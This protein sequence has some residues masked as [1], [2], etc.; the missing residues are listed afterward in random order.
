MKRKKRYC[1][2]CRWRI[3]ETECRVWARKDGHDSP[4]Q[5]IQLHHFASE[6]QN[7]NNDCAWFQFS[8]WSLIP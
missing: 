7:R 8:F 6:E 4:R 5:K 2:R 3:D 1:K